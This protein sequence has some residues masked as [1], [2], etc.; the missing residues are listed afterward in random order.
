MP[1]GGTAECC[2]GRLT[3]VVMDGDETLTPERCDETAIAMIAPWR[4]MPMPPPLRMP[5]WLMIFI[6]APPTV[7]MSA[8][9]AGVRRALAVSC[10]ASTLP[11]R[12][13]MA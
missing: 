10:V 7:G 3:F 8:G 1:R 2:R 13:S 6:A 9:L 5:R 4:E 12:R 11:R